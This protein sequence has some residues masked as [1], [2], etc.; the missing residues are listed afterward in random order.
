MANSLLDASISLQ[1]LEYNAYHHISISCPT[2]PSRPAS[3]V[4]CHD[5]NQRTLVS[6]SLKFSHHS[7]TF[8]GIN[9]SSLTLQIQLCEFV[10]FENLS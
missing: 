3:V 1:H 8:L 4:F 2:I 7:R 9:I 6:L 10:A 5:S